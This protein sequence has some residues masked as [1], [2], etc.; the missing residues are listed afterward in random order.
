MKKIQ[1]GMITV[2]NDNTIL[3]VHSVLKSTLC[4]LRDLSSRFEKTLAESAWDIPYLKIEKFPYFVIKSLNQI[5]S[6]YNFSYFVIRFLLN[7]S[8]VKS[9]NKIGKVYDKKKIWLINPMT[10]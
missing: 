1:S 2:W 9:D 10:K 4:E 5:F 3:H 8:I 7:S 6:A